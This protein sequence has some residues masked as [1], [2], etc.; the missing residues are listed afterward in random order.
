MQKLFVENAG[1]E[2]IYLNEEQSRHVARS[3]RMKKGDMITV[4]SGDGR[5]QGC[6]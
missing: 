3:L 2:L 5:F 6:R 1:G 4:C